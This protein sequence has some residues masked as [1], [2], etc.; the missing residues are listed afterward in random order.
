MGLFRT[1]LRQAIG[2]GASPDAYK[3]SNIWYVDAA[4][5]EAAANQMITVWE[6]ILRPSCTQMVYAYEVYASDLVPDTTNFTTIGIVPGHQRGTSSTA[7]GDGTD[8]Y[9]PAVALRIDMHV[10]GGFASR[11]W[12]RVGLNEA[13]VAPGGLTM[14]NTSWQTAISNAYNDVTEVSGMVDESGH[15]FTGATLVGIRAKRLGKFARFDLPIP[16]AFG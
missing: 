13:A 8:F 16:P 11:K 14:S 7:T 5:V 9:T 1:V 2:G 15:P 3:W 6:D 4:D 10:A 12:V